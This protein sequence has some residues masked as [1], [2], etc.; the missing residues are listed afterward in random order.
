M[1]KVKTQL[2]V[3]GQNRTRKAFNEVDN[4][5]TSLSGKAK[6]AGSALAGAFSVGVMAN[7]LKN[8]A[9]AVEQ[10]SRLASLSGASAA[11]FQRWAYAAKSVGFEQDKLGD[12]F[13]DVQDK[14]GD[15]LQTGGGPM[16][17]FF[18]NIAPKVGVTAENFRN[19]SGPDALQLYVN[20]LEKAN[21]SQSEMTFYL[22][23]IANDAALLLPL[24][25]QNGAAAR[26]LGDEAERLGRI[27]DEETTESIRRFNS[28][29]RDLSG[30]GQGL[31]NQVTGVAAEAINATGV[32]DTF[33]AS[34]DRM[35][36]VVKQANQAQ[37]PGWLDK[38]LEYFRLLSRPEL[39]DAALGFLTFGFT[40][41]SAGVA[42]QE[43]AADDLKK[44]EQ[45]RVADYTESVNQLKAKQT[46][47]VS[48]AEAALKAMVGAEKAAATELEAAKK[49]QLDTQK[50]YSDALAK[51]NAGAGPEASLIGV[52]SLR[53]A[54]N[55]ALRAG[56][57]EGAKA[58]AQ[59]ALEMLQQLA[60]AGANTYGFAGFIKSLQAIEDQADQI[61]VD[62]AKNSFDEVQQKAID[63]KELLD[64]IST[65]V[66]SV[67]MD[68]K[69]LAK[70]RADIE[71]LSKLAAGETVAS[72][73]VAATSESN[74]AGTPRAATPPPSAAPIRQDGHNSF[75]NL[76]PVEVEVVPTGIRQDGP[77]SFTNLPPVP[78]DVLPQGIRQDGE[79]SFT[80]LPPLSVDLQVDQE[81]SS[82]AQQQI[83][84]LAQQFA[85]QL[86]IPVTPVVGAAG[87][88]QP[89][90]VDKFAT[91]GM[92]RG[93]GSGTSDSI[94]ALLSNG[95][96]VIR[97]AAVS[98]LGQGFLDL[99]N[100]G[101]PISRFADGGLVEA[102]TL[103]GAA[104]PA[105]KSFGR[106]DIALGDQVLQ[107]YV[108]P[109]PSLG[110]ELKR[111][112][113]KFGS[114]RLR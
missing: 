51:V 79:N 28:S 61:S 29:L 18:E 4:S 23:A 40:K 67:Q 101:M 89:A 13:K 32:I 114:T 78:V 9:A 108:Q 96:Y 2:I 30:A 112:R 90:Q 46:E 27:L 38:F 17:D 66:I 44:I 24:L 52:M 72:S 15:F 100:R 63:L 19:L 98:R 33:T 73:A 3:E 85:A 11:Q 58:N 64:S 10:M 8:T 83:A 71:A 59:A 105:F 62:K 93:P 60:D 36:G 14:V 45:Q 75:T 80:N 56:D 103:A 113:M 70:A 6:A 55:Q 102:S 99:L 43:S 68:E 106:L 104:E 31:A 57:V 74:R 41:K 54:A 26:A 48:N 91:G 42:E 5:L 39:T 47:A 16:A 94:P 21:L 84:A 69:A 34:V 20:S 109:S 49:A 12:I 87:A 95:E 22:E 35:S 82:Q 37:A 7:F 65:T 88:Q 25:S 111:A 107:T 50:R 110:Q 1:S 97:A 81:A 86:V 92:V 53:N 77:N 76:P